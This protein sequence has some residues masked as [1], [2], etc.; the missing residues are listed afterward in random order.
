MSSDTLLNILRETDA[1]LLASQNSAEVRQIG[2][3]HVRALGVDFAATVYLQIS[4]S[5]S[6]TPTQQSIFLMRAVGGLIEA[7]ESSF[8][9]QKVQDA[10]LLT[11]HLEAVESGFFTQFD[12]L[13]TMA[14]MG[15]RA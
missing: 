4:S 6:L 8:V 2:I 9:T 15:G 5:P 3:D 11:D 1:K 7:I 10:S 12:K 13:M 14:Q